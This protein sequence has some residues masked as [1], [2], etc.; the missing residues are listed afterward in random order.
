V[1]LLRDWLDRIASSPAQ[2]DEHHPR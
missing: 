1:L 2:L